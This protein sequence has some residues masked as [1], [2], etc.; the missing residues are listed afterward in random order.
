MKCLQAAVGQG[1]VD[2]ALFLLDNGAFV[3]GLAA[4][5]SGGVTALQAALKLFTRDSDCKE[6]DKAKDH[7]R[8][9]LLKTL[10]NAE[11][12]L[13]SPRSPNKLLSSLIIAV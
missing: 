8:F 5:R 1:H 6:T 11:A 9:A 12:D 2:I 4:A 10:L 13:N 7:S 3:N